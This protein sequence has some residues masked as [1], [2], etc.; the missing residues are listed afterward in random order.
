MSKSQISISHMTGKQP[1][2]LTPK[3]SVSARVCQIPL[4][5]AK[6]VDAVLLKKSTFFFDTSPV[7][8]GDFL[9]SVNFFF[10]LTV[11]T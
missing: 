6:S 5:F 10:T 4:W 3:G 8:L 9:C 2:R 11:F 7:D 1:F